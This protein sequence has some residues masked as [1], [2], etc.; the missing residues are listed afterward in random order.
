MR[1]LPAG[2][3]LRRARSADIDR[4]EGLVQTELRRYSEWATGWELGPPP[5]DMMQRLEPLFDDDERAWVLM[6][7]HGVEVVGVA[8]LSVTTGAMPEPP[9]PGT[10]YLWQMFARRDWHGTGLAGALLDRVIEEARRRG[11]QRVIL[12]A[13][14]G[15]KQARRFYEK[16]GFTPTGRDQPDSSL[17]LALVEYGRSV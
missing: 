13:A 6:A 11:C 2:I 3:E 9:P 10:V 15:A 5:R 17:G 8:S 12:W 16:E 4:V 7:L 1:A 14:A